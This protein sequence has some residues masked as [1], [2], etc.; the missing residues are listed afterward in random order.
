[1][2][3][4]YLNRSYESHN[5]FK[6][7]WI[8]VITNLSTLISKV[9][10]GGCT[11]EI[12]FPSIENA[13]RAYGFTDSLQNLPCLSGILSTLI[14]HQCSK[15]DYPDLGWQKGNDWKYIF[16][17]LRTT[18]IKG[19][20]KWINPLFERVVCQGSRIGFKTETQ[21]RDTC[22]ILSACRCKA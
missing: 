22:T 8:L 16:K 7:I 5:S 3:A 19:H 13:R 18:H 21:S 20:W 14:G 4:L 9:I 2:Y 11:R 17:P 10:V 6:I 1:M 12:F 15:A